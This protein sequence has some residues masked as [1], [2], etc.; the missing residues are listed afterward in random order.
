MIRFEYERI[1]GT[2]TL[3]HYRTFNTHSKLTVS[4]SFCRKKI[5]K[6][7]F[8]IYFIKNDIS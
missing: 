1:F 5:A 4:K 8:V 2:A 3:E 7:C 6:L